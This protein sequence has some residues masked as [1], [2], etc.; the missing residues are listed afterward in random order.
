MFMEGYRTGI[1]YILKRHAKTV[2]TDED[3]SP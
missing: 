3:L 2:R 1:S